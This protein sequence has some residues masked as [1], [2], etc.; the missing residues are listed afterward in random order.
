MDSSTLAPVSHATP[1]KNWDLKG[2]FSNAVAHK[3]SGISAERM[4]R[5]E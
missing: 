5:L 2:W 3:E 4:A 1:R